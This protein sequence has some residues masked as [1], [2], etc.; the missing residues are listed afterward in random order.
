MRDLLFMPNAW[1]NLGW[2][3]KNDLKTMKKIYALLES[4]SKTPI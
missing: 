1:D 4:I 2:W 3:I